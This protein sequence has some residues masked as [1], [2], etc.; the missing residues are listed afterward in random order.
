MSNSP[1]GPSEITVFTPDVLVKLNGPGN[2]NL[3]SAWYDILL[4]EFGVATIRDRKFHDQ[5]RRFWT[6]GFSGKGP[7]K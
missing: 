1:L 2:S 4:P 3:K 6:A 7:F 5:R